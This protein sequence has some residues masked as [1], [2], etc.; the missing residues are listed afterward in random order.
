MPDVGLDADPTTGM[1]VGQTQTFPDGVRIRRVPDRR[2]QPRLA[3]VRRHDRAARS[4]TPA[5]GG[6]GLLN[7]TIYGQSRAGT[8]TD[9]KGTPPDAGNVR[10]DYVNGV[11]ASDGLLYWV[12]TFNQDSSLQIAPGLGRRHR[13]RLAEPGL[14]EGAD[15]AAGGLIGGRFILGGGACL[16]ARAPASSIRPCLS[17]ALAL[18][19]LSRQTAGP[20]A[21]LRHAPL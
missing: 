6:A 16:R 10:V 1:L 17:A 2:H 21:L 15:S 5:A 9:V 4:S 12:R 19:G 11:D 7:P 8:F 20:G 18:V 3:A 14:A 13:S